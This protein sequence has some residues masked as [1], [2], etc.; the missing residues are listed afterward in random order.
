MAL[1]LLLMGGEQRSFH[2]HHHICPRRFIWLKCRIIT[3]VYL[4]DLAQQVNFEILI[5]IINMDL[6]WMAW[7]N[8]LVWVVVIT[9]IVKKMVG[10]R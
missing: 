5:I 8:C 7:N 6:K 2:Y 4:L 1:L 10:K 9:I 3:N